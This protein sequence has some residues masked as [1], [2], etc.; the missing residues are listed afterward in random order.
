MDFESFTKDKKTVRVSAVSHIP[1]FGDAASP[2]GD[3]DV[4]AG[5]GHL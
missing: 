1:Q 2:V 5:D 3:V 4:S